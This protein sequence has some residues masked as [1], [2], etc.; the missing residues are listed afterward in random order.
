MGAA[1]AEAVGLGVQVAA[2]LTSFLT[3]LSQLRHMRRLWQVGQLVEARTRVT[4]YQPR[5]T[6]RLEC[7]KPGPQKGTRK[8]NEGEADL[9]MVGAREQPTI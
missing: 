4:S 5:Q 2:P 3:R 1:S 6:Q 8:E 7:G 9:G